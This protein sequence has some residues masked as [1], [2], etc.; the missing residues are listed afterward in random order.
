[1][2]QI[3]NR[4]TPTYICEAFSEIPPKISSIFSAMGGE[5]LCRVLNSDQNLS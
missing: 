5:D 3:Y 4:V 2:T 1:M